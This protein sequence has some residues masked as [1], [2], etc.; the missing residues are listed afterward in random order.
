MVST[1]INQ[2]HTGFI[3]NNKS[4]ELKHKSNILIHKIVQNE[5]EF[6]KNKKIELDLDAL[7]TDNNKH[8]EFKKGAIKIE[9]VAFLISG[10]IIDDT[11]FTDYNIRVA[12]E[13]TDL[14]SALKLFP[15][16]EKS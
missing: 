6:A 12:A 3:A 16:K 8:Y 10:N 7:L 5:N 14:A 13:N 11:F 2:S 4:Y 9:D 1:S 15:D